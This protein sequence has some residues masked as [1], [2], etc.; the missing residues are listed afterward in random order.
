LATVFL[1]AVLPAAICLAASRVNLGEEVTFEGAFS[2]F[3][4]KFWRLFGLS[5][6]QGIYAGWPLIIA[7]FVAV[8][9]STGLSSLGGTPA[10]LIAFVLVLGGIPSLALYTRYALAYPATAIEA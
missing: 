10:P 8:F 1:G 2:S 9:I 5:I 7:A 6:L 3:T 4:S